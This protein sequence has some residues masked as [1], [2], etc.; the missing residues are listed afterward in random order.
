MGIQLSSIRPYIK[1]I[2][3][4][5]NPCH[6]SHQIVLERVA[7]FHEKYVIYIDMYWVYYYSYKMN[8]QIFKNFSIFSSNTVII[9]RCNPHKQNLLEVLNYSKLCKGSFGPETK[10]SELC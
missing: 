8:L 9:K 2:Y 1:E 10:K 3:K 4:S 6:L 7:I 5:A